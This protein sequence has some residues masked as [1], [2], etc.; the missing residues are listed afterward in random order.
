[1]NTMNCLATE[2]ILVGILYREASLAGICII[3]RADTSEI[4][5]KIALE[6]NSPPQTNYF[7]KGS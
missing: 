1:M 5:Y 7:R 4:S 2:E 3:F 6:K